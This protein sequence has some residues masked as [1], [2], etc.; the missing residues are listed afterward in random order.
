[1]NRKQGKEGGGVV[2]MGVI[3]CLTGV[4]ENITRDSTCI[5]KQSYIYHETLIS[6]LNE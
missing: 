5:S 3:M 2:G 1:M 6:G 4:E